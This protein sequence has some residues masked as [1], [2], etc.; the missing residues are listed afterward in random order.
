MSRRRSRRQADNGSAT[1][2]GEKPV[3]PKD[4]GAFVMVADPAGHAL[5]EYARNPR[6]EIDAVIW[7]SSSTGDTT[8]LLDRADEEVYGCKTCRDQGRPQ[9][10]FTMDKLAISQHL[11]LAFAESQYNDTPVHRTVVA[12]SV[13]D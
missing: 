11:T 10:W 7:L 4:Q 5:A 13:V 9:F 3:T 6:D 1:F 2:R 12:R 8:V